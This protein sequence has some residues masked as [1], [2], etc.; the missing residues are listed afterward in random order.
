LQDFARADRWQLSIGIMIGSIFLRR[1]PATLHPD[2]V[3]ENPGSAH[4]DPIAASIENKETC[5]PMRA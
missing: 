3:E 4:S 5:S 2:P 1:S